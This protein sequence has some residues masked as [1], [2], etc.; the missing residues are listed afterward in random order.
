MIKALGASLLLLLSVAQ[1]AE[2]GDCP[3]YKASSVKRTDSGLTADLKLAGKAC[4]VYG[5]DIRDLRLIVEYQTDSRLHVLIQDTREQV[6]QI[7]EELIPRPPASKKPAAH[8]KLKFDLTESPFSFTV[9]RRD[10]KEVLFDTSSDKLIF[11][12]Q[13]VYLKTSLPENPNLYGLGEHPDS[14]RLF[15]DQDYS[16]TMWN[17]ESPFL[18]RKTNLYGSQPMY[19]EHRD[20]G[21]HGVLLLNSNGMDVK[22]AKTDNGHSLAYNIIGGVLDFYFFA[23]PDPVEVS[24]QHAQA[25]GL[26]AMMPYWSLGYQQAKYGYWD[27]NILAEM[28]AN[29]STANIPLE[30]VWADIDYMHYRKD[31]TLDPDRFPLWKTRELVDTLHKRKQKFVMMLDPGISTDQGYDSYSRGH[32]QGAYLKAKDGSDYRGVQ[33]AGA[34]AWP[35]YQSKEGLSWWTDEIKRFFDAGTGVNVDG[36]WND[37]NEGSNFCPDTSCNPEQHA[38]D[39]NTPPEP[40]NPPRNNTGRPIPGFPPSFQPD[41]SSTGAIFSASSAS[42][43]EHY[44]GEE[45]RRRK[46]EEEGSLE[47]RRQTIREEETKGDKKGLPG[48][49][50]FTP[51]YTIDNKQGAL[52]ARTIWTNISNH[53]GTHQY[54]THNMY[55]LTM[56][57]ATHKA[58]LA[59]KP[60]VRP[61]VLTRSNFLTTGAWA[62]HWFGDNYSS[63]DDYRFAISQMLAY[64]TVHNI[65]MVGSDVCGFNGDAQENMCARWAT[66][67]A[68]QP[69]MRNH[70]D[71]SAPQQE[72]YKWPTVIS[73]AQ[74]ALDARYRLLDYIYS[75][76]FLA[77]KEGTPSVSPLFY[78]YPSDKNVYYNQ[79]Q[80]FLGDSILVSPVIENDATSVTYYLPDDV[81][82]DFWTLEQVR[83][84]GATVTIDNVPWTDIPVHYRGG[85]VVPLRVESANTT[86]DLR[87]KDFHIVVAPGLDGKA[88]GTL[89]LD[90]GE[91]VEGAVSDV[92]FFW[93]GEK[94]RVNGNFH[95]RSERKVR[96]VTILGEKG[97]RTAKGEWSLDRAFE[98]TRFS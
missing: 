94:L 33:W 51:K 47:L 9:S 90:D 20:S 56:V 32:E 18:P 37:M 67:A 55:G 85:K 76:L 13:Y 84:K 31:F 34:V 44:T 36:I 70:A 19:I 75:A 42:P 30:V 2:V 71:I 53:D 69:F 77:H 5:D 81:F 59:R 28:A 65:P 25:L 4:D 54:D 83:G 48:R 64:A 79:E 41:P 57:K 43:V 35:D 10:T 27:V 21:T 11:E 97:Q 38:K 58:M 92:H 23:G 72:F 98:V 91:S 46:E 29:Y 17:R 60:N 95:Y 50:L 87:D 24:K 39:T 62:A 61:F 80:W 1:A 73:A 16:R 40:S 66:M 14:F 96:E 68:F 22:L 49:D 6:F 93:N 8:S 15:T 82:Y 52:S 89:F 12:S 3:G 7:Q 63:W 78:Q 26:P 86:A 74:K 45:L 88:T